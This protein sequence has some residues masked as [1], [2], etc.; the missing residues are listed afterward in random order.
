MTDMKALANNF[1]VA[2]IGFRDWREKG[3]VILN[4]SIILRISASHCE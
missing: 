2:E 1:G 4:K 3:L